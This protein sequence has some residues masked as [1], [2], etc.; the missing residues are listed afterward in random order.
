MDQTSAV[1]VIY[2]ADKRLLRFLWWTDDYH[3]NSANSAWNGDSVQLM[4]ASADRAVPRS[5]L[6]NY[7]PRRGGRCNDGHDRDAMRPDPV[8]TEAVVTRDFR[9]PRRTLLRDFKLPA[10]RLWALLPP[11]TIGTKFGLGN[12]DQRRR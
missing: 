2:D 9:S 8:G 10:S 11:L 12:G 1:Q 5:A 6:Y 4:I 3:E 7:A